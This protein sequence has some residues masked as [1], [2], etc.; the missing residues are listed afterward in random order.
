MVIATQVQGKLENSSGVLIDAIGS[1]Q[2]P[3]NIPKMI[4]DK[5]YT[6]ALDAQLAVRGRGAFSTP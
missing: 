5:H 6:E 2:I 3:K 1:R 4:G